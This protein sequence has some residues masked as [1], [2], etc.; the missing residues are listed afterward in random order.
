MINITA[1][2]SVLL[3]RL[4]ARGRDSEQ[5][6]KERV[7]R[8]KKLEPTGPFVLDVVNEGTREEGIDALVDILRAYEPRPPPRVVFL[9]DAHTNSAEQLELAAAIESME[10]ADGADLWMEYLLPE[11][12]ATMRAAFE[13]KSAEE[14]FLDMER[15]GENDELVVEDSPPKTVEEATAEAEGVPE[16]AVGD[17]EDSPYGGLYCDESALRQVM[18][19]VLGRLGWPMELEDSMVA[20]LRTAHMKGSVLHALDEADYTLAAFEE[21]Q[22]TKLAADGEEE[23]T[24]A[25]SAEAQRFKAQMEYAHDRVN[26]A[27]HRFL[28]RV[29]AYGG[30]NARPQLLL[31]GLEHW[32]ALRNGLE[33]R[34]EGGPVELEPVLPSA[35]ASKP[36]EAGEG[37]AQPSVDHFATAAQACQ[38]RRAQLAP[39]RSASL[40]GDAESEDDMEVEPMLAAVMGAHHPTIYAPSKIEE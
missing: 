38:E 31:C 23:L 10:L 16:E 21:K 7:A 37:E 30:L 28:G 14:Y 8:S 12:V 40:F 26:N 39:P 29:E 6:I 33:T 25:P 5:S 4:T 11:E 36:A 35:V 1:S 19:G 34:G 17:E 24:P 15:E 22:Q 2:E 3:E 18:Q 20:L 9:A 32:E 27:A 13:D